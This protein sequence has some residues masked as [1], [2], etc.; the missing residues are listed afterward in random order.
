MEEGG[1]FRCDFCLLVFNRG[2]ERGWDGVS[3]F[4]DDL[5]GNEN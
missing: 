1:V 2:V 4:G 5:E 3:I